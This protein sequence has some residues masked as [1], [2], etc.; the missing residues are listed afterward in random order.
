MKKLLVLLS[1]SLLAGCSIGSIPLYEVLPTE[2]PTPSVTVTAT[3]TPIH[4]AT[5]APTASG[6]SIPTASTMTSAKIALVDVSPATPGPDA[7]GCG[8]T[9]VMVSPATP[10]NNLQG[11]LESLLAIKQREYQYGN[12]P[13]M[14]VLADAHVIVNAA[15]IADG[16]ATVE[17]EGYFTFA[18]TCDV[19]RVKEQIKRTIM[20]FPEVKSYTILL[21]GSAKEYEC[22]SDQSGNCK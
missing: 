13:L 21:N 7:F 17:F 12:R 5:T 6:S 18:G 11:A 15:T 10:V 19:P 16:K 1:S 20:Q 22:L 2:T 9:I 14:N 3:P 8:D 4:T